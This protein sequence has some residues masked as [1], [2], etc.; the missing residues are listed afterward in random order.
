MQLR[1]V[2]GKNEAT[3][4]CGVEAIKSLVNRMK[5]FS[6]AQ[7]EFCNLLQW[8][9][10]N[11][12]SR[13]PGSLSYLEISWVP[14]GPNGVQALVGAFTLSGAQLNPVE[15]CQDVKR[16][17]NQGALCVSRHFADCFNRHLKVRLKEHRMNRE[18]GVPWNHPTGRTLLKSWFLS[19]DPGFLPCD[20][21]L[22]MDKPIG[23]GTGRNLNVHPWIRCKRRYGFL[24]FEI[25]SQDEGW[26]SN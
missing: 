8:T 14:S 13:G 17:T 6:N 2:L 11:G 26:N 16:W 25:L 10:C 21:P 1:P 23:P 15:P 24:H 5:S 20:T 18:A 9:F 7:C 19:N 12:Y 4:G 22:Y 3:N